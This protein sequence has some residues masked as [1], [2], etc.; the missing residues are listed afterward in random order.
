MKQAIGEDV[1]A[2]GIG[3]KL[4]FVER[5]KGQVGPRRHGFGG[6]QQPARALGLDRSSPV[7][8]A[9]WAGPLIAQTRS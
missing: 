7:I 9:T 8:S 3:G 4:R 6:A 2:F 5:D 1:A